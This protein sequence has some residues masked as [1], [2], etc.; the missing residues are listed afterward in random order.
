MIH[1]HYDR[2]E[3]F[4]YFLII[5]VGF[6]VLIKAYGATSIGTNVQSD[7]SF[8]LSSSTSTLQFSNGWK[9]SQT[10]ATTSQVSV[11]DSLNAPVLIFDEN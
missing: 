1:K 9:M 4:V 3:H 8:L 10:S 11:T 7:G 2:R 5:A 6:F